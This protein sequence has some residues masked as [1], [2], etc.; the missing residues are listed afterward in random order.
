MAITLVQNIGLGTATTAGVTSTIDEPT[1]AVNQSQLMMTGNWFAATSVNGGANWVHVDPFTLF[2]AAVGGFCCDQ[3]VLYNPGHQ[4]WV[5]LLQYSP[6]ATGHNLFRLAVSRAA[7]FGSWYYWDFS[8]TNLN[9]TWTTMEFDYPDMAFSNNNLFVT[10][11]GYVANAWQRAF[12]F[13]FPLATLAAGTSL[14]Y[15]WWTT[16]SNGSLRLTQ[17]AGATMHF[18]SHNSLSQIR[19]FDWPDASTSLS[20]VDVNVRSW[21]GGPYSS[22]PVPG[23]VNWLGRVD[24]RITGAGVGAGQIGFMWTASPDANHPFPYIRVVRINETTKALVDEPDIWSSRGAWAY[25][26]AAPNSA[27]QIGV[28]AFY[29]GGTNHHP[30]H[31]VGV[32]T[33]TAWDTVLTATST[34]DPATP[35]WGDYLSCLMHSPTTAHWVASGYTMQG[36]TSRTNVVPRYVEFHS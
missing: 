6:T 36:G 32:R 15:N 12:V 25:P 3:T 20:W 30:G 18:G 26:G 4:I 28:S 5:W 21:S 22:G 2:P 31:V 13:R 14:G 11:N 1:A 27:G 16:T 34:N 7:S 19:V 8:P 17:G 9:A 29:G 35:A 23:G 33:A 10:I 24:S